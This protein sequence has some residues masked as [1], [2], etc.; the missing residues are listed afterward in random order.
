MANLALKPKGRTLLISFSRP[1][2]SLKFTYGVSIAVIPAAFAATAT[3][4]R[5]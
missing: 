5:G 3:T 1:S 2:L 4:E